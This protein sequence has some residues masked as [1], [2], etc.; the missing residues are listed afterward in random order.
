MFTV[1]ASKGI[2]HELRV[3]QGL[4]VTVVFVELV[5]LVDI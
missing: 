4:G 3:G 1:L 5:L 2:V